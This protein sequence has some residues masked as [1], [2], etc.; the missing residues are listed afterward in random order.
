MP[1]HTLYAYVDG[2]DLEDV[3]TQLEARFTEFVASRQ[4]IA[5]VASVINQR[6]GRD[7]CTQ[8][9]DLPLWDLGLTLQL[10]D[11]GTEPPGWF[12]DVEAVALFLGTLHCECGR[13]FIVGIADTKTGITDDLFAVSTDSPDL[14]RLRAIIGVADVQ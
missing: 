8:P 5:G 11:P 3:A 10:P 2:A 12:T 13:D 6:H 14:G 7:T 1:K 4:W 9:G